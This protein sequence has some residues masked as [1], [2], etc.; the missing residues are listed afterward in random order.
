[1][2]ARTHARTPASPAYILLEY[3]ECVCMHPTRLEE[4][5]IVVAFASVLSCPVRRG[6]PPPLVSRRRETDE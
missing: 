4:L 6:L 3:I 5:D 2:H 1:M